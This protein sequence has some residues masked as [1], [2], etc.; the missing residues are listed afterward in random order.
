MTGRIP[1]LPLAFS[2]TLRT[3]AALA[4][5]NLLPA[6]RPPASPTAPGEPDPGS[7]EPVACDAA[8]PCPVP[9]DC[10]DGACE[11]A[12]CSHEEFWPLATASSR[13]PLLV[14]YR[15][16]DEAGTAAE[17]LDY[18]ERY[19]DVEV[20][21]L[22]FEPP[23]P[24]AARCGPDDSFD[25]FLWRGYE[26][27]D[28]ESLGDEPS[29]PWDDTPTYLTLDPW[30]PYGGEHLDSTLA[31]E[32][33]H[34]LQAVHDWNETPILFEMT[35]QFIEEVVVPDDDAWME[36]L[37]DYQ[38]HPDWAFDFDDDYD[39]FYFYGAGL[40]F[41]YLREAVFHGEA[42]FLSGLWRACRNPP[43]VNE[44][45]FEDALETILAPHHLTFLESLVEFTRWR[46][47]TAGRDDGRHFPDGASFPPEAMVPVERTL[48]ASPQVVFVEPGPM[49]LGAVFLEVARESDAPGSIA[50]DLKGDPRVHW[51]VQAVPGLT[52]DSDGDILDLSSGP[53][54]LR[55]GSLASRTL[56]ILALPSGPD[57][58]DDR[59]PERFP[60]TL[61]LSPAP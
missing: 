42:S 40:Y 2:I 57:D 26:G 58:P 18:L 22:G 9:F 12:P 11:A 20:H 50:I 34:A 24:D 39:T 41:L 14:H 61:T 55:F 59:S 7:D 30:G 15:E 43:G 32:L 46:W 48:A 4:A 27:G 52:P 31:H 36:Y 37:F 25:V 47:Y 21:T 8:V 33:N 16:A 56:V 28:V 54:T 29:T 45:D 5:C 44:P 35:A 53:A 10:L 38:A 23:L 60:F 17:V 51:S 6:C 49:M 1:S 3:C 19:W 13:L